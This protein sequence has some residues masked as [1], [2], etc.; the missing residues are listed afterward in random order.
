VNSKNLFVF[1][2][3]FFLFGFACFLLLSDTACSAVFFEEGFNGGLEESSSWV[4]VED[5]LPP[6]FFDTN[7]VFFSSSTP[8]LFPYLYSKSGIFPDNNVQIVVR[9][10]YINGCYN[11]GSGIVVADQILTE[12][13]QGVAG[14][15]YKTLFIWPLADGDLGLFSTL[16]PLTQPDCNQKPFKILKGD[17]SNEW[18]EWKVVFKD[19]VYQMYFDENLMFDS[20]STN[21]TPKYVWIGNPEI[22]TNPGVE[23]FSFQVDWIRVESLGED[24]RNKVVFLPGLGGSWNTESLVTGVGVPDE[25]WVLTPFTNVYDGLI[26]TFEAN[27]YVKDKDLFVYTYDWRDPLSEIAGRFEGFLSDKISNGE[28][29]DLVGHSL[30]GLVARTY[31]QT[32]NDAKVDKVVTLGSPHEGAVQAYGVWA[33]G[34]IRE[35]R[36]LADV[37][38]GAFLRL[39]S[40][41]GKNNWEVVKEMAPVVK[42]IMPSFDFAYRGS[43]LISLSGMSD[44][45]EFL[46]GL[47]SNKIDIYPKLEAVVGTGF[48]TP[49]GVILGQRSLYD[50][51]LGL[52]PDGSLLGYEMDNGDETVLYRSAGFEGDV[53]SEVATSHG[54][55]ASTNEGIDSLMGILELSGH[56]LGLAESDWSDTLLFMIGSPAGLS[57]LPPSGSP[58]LADDQGIVKFSP[59]VPGSYMVSVSGREDGIY[60]LLS[61]V[62]SEEL[63][64]LEME[65]SLGQ[66][67]DYLFFVD[68]EGRMEMIDFDGLRW[69]GLA[70]DLVKNRL[71]VN[72][73]VNL[74]QALLNIDDAMVD[75]SDCERGYEGVNLA[76]ADLF[77]Y[78][79]SEVLFE[80][81]NISKQVV[82]YLIE[83]GKSFSVC[84]GGVGEEEAG[85]NLLK[86]RQLKAL[87]NAKLRLFVERGGGLE[88]IR[89]EAYREA[90]R[91]LVEMVSDLA[92]GNYHE[93]E[94]KARAVELCLREAV[95]G[96]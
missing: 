67:D 79:S 69:L 81:R 2:F 56:N 83:A 51:I 74:D 28:K 44:R 90:E 62:L 96:I 40:G 86:M 18:H 94:I 6:L 35:K 34:Q 29:V 20:V 60:H 72:G 30:G 70:R 8:A 36:S 42:D 92:G 15:K 78:R 59:V 66:E 85:E 21:R 43:Q 32:S 14:G 37:A 7:S 77:L 13:T 93:V 39:Q 22:T 88:L 16:C 5:G 87:V 46:I 73:N 55:L 95:V 25:D 12:R 82:G 17:Y 84:M 4:E 48:D 54:G 65:T 64:Y 10:K 31:E 63:D 75:V 24:G 33:G 61:G 19:G 91:L 57:V 47:N 38:L 71:M 52:W 1:R 50:Q 9:F 58:V 76:M 89:V 80:R 45:N 68:S 27:G 26:S 23:W 41:F 49:G 3:L 53:F 11:Y